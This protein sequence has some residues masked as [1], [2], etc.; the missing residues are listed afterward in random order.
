MHQC[1]PRSLHAG[2]R[3]QHSESQ[4][5]DHTCPDLVRPDL[6]T[7]KTHR[8]PPT[9]LFFIEIGSSLGRPASRCLGAGGQAMGTLTPVW[10][11]LGSK[12]EASAAAPSTS[13]QTRGEDI[14]RRQPLLLLPH[15]T[16]QWILLWPLPGESEVCLR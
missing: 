8:P 7:L 2:W 12:R 14:Q 13:S 10:C 3:D 6:L 1:H 4:T 11:F 16:R 9:T 15:S 5:R